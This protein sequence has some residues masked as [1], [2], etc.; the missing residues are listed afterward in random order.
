VLIFADKRLSLHNQKS[1]FKNFYLGIFRNFSIFSES[2]PKVRAITVFEIHY[3]QGNTVKG[4]EIFI[5]VIFHYSGKE[6]FIQLE[7]MSSQ[8]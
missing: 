7:R 5:N 6:Y 1:G 2:I 4:L 8:Q 3:P